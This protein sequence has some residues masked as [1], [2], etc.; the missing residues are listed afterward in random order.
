M[1][2]IRP[3]FD[4]PPVIEQA[5]TLMFEPI[6]GFNIGDIGRFWDRVRPDFPVCQAVRHGRRFHDEGGE[7]YLTTP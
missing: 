6:E 1:T 4:D 5:I 2:P 3:E 7:I